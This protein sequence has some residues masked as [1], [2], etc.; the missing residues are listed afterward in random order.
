MT[1]ARLCFRR[2]ALFRSRWL[3]N[4]ARGQATEA[5]IWSRQTGKTVSIKLWESLAVAVRVEDFG[6]GGVARIKLAVH[7]GQE[8]KRIFVHFIPVTSNPLCRIFVGDHE[9]R[10]PASAETSCFVSAEDMAMLKMTSYIVRVGA[11]RIDGT[12]LWGRNVLTREIRPPMKHQR[13]F[14][15]K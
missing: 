4:F 10:D 3:L 7:P 12:H 8:T 14:G 15:S 5:R 6:E 9:V 2:E 13:F 1:K 11:Q